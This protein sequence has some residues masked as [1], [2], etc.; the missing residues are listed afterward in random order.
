MITKGDN[1]FHIFIGHLYFSFEGFSMQWLLLM[2]YLSFFSFA[3]FL[4]HAM[5]PDTASP[6][7]SSLRTT[8][9]FPR[10][11]FS[12][13]PIQKQSRTSGNSNGVP[14]CNKTRHQ[15]SYQNWTRLSN[16]MKRVLRVGKRVRDIPSRTLSCTT[17]TYMQRT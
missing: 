12:P 5:H 8:S 15:S 7:S 2:D 16:R 13:F 11:T 10:Y 6:P 17:I 1:V 3:L 9:Y 4:S 14:R